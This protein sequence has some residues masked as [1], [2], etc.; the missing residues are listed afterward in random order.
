[1][2][3]DQLLYEC[4]G[5]NEALQDIYRHPWRGEHGWENEGATE[6]GWKLQKVWQARLY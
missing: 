6:T 4:R 5:L 1:M 2:P 3:K